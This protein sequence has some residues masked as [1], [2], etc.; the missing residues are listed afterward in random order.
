MVHHHAGAEGD[1]ER[2]Y[3]TGVGPLAHKPPH[4]RYQCGPTKERPPKTGSVTISRVEQVAGRIT[5]TH[6]EEMQ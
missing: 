1:E 6:R 2:L 3:D 4:R 5:S